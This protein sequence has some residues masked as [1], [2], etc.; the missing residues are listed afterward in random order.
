MLDKRLVDT[1]SRTFEL[2]PSSVSPDTNPQNTPAW[3]SVGHLN[4]ILELEEVF[5]VRFPSQDIGE[6]N[7]AARLQDAISKLAAG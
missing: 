5:Q 4:L 1:I 6:L 2:E 3:D 7:S